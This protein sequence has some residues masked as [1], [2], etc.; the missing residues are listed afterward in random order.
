[1]MNIRLLMRLSVTELLLKIS[2]IIY[3]LLFTGYIAASICLGSIYLWVCLIALIFN[4]DMSGRHKVV[5]L[6]I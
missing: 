4:P 3:I 5:E 1:L 2:I 6:Y